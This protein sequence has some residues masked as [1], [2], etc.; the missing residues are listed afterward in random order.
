[1][2]D[3]KFL[4]DKQVD[5]L[6]AYLQLRAGKNG[7][8]RYAGQ[9]YAQKIQLVAQGLEPAPLGFQAAKLTLDDAVAVGENAT[10][11]PGQVF[12][13]DWPAPLNIFLVDRSYWLA[14]N[15]LPVTK[16][17][18]LRGRLDLP[19]ALHRLPRREGRRRQRGRQVPA[20]A[21][22]RLHQ[23]RRRLRR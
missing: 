18:L 20:S 5:D 23:R 13:L 9:L 19:G 15:P 10:P 4:S 2:P 11:P 22:H 12:G 21:A 14:D 7:L 3:F 6:S 1:M 16:D 8:V 17:N